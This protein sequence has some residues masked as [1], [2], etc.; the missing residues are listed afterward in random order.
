MWAVNCRHF[1]MKQTY[2]DTVNNRF[3][4]WPIDDFASNVLYLFECRKTQSEIGFVRQD[5]KSTSEKNGCSLEI[6]NQFA[7]TFYQ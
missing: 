7:R 3:E 2:R 4:L 1:V 5:N 6:K